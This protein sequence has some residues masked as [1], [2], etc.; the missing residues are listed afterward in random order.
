MTCR[1]LRLAGVKRRGLP[2]C[3]RGRRKDELGCWRRGFRRDRNR[4]SLRN[5]GCLADLVG[6]AH[7]DVED[8]GAPKGVAG[9]DAGGPSTVAEV[10]RIAFDRVSRPGSRHRTVERH[11][12]A[13]RRVRRREHEVG[14]WRH[15]RIDGDGLGGRGAQA[16]I[17]DNRQA[18]AERS[19]RSEPM[20]CGAPRRR[21]PIAEIPGEAD[22]VAV[23]QDAS[24]S[25][26]AF[27][28]A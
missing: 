3:W 9:A 10:P 2:G 12:L 27:R 21:R 6:R 7:N 16:A 5:D 23:G 22:E 13:D 26:R 14:L 18:Y 19:E 4:H 28:T 8:A 15:A 24:A 17:G 11:A 25:E 1:S 20:G